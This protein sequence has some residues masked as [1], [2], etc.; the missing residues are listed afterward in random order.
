MRALFTILLDVL[1]AIG[2][3]PE[4]PNSELITWRVV[5]GE[6]VVGSIDGKCFLMLARLQTLEKMIEMGNQFPSAEVISG[7]ADLQETSTAHV[8]VKFTQA[9]DDKNFLIT[10]LRT[11]SVLK[12][13]ALVPA[14]CEH[15]GCFYIAMPDGCT[16]MR[17]SMPDIFGS[18]W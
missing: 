13:R 14:E 16:V 6:P 12:V 9:S 15:T 4:L 7:L 18:S 2:E 1:N 10:T 5:K 11:L 17:V 8:A 3:I